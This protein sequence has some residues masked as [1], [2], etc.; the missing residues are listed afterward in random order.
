VGISLG[1]RER[2]T[3]KSVTKPDTQGKEQFAR[4]AR[5]PKKGPKRKGVNH[6]GN[7][8]AGAVFAPQSSRSSIK[9][10]LCRLIFPRA[11]FDLGENKNEEK[12]RRKGGPRR[13]WKPKK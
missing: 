4:A 10:R 6:G 9:K 8:K 12:A 7:G 3:G 1:G 13:P 11:T 2:L 5:G